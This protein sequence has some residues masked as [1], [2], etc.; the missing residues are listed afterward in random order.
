V[1]TV[2]LD[3]GAS[4][5]SGGDRYLEIYV[6][7]HDAPAYTGLTPRQQINSTPYAIRTL[8]AAAADT[9]TNAAQLGGVA[10]SGYVQTNDARLSDPRAPLA[11]SSNYI[12]NSSTQQSGTFNVNGSGTIGGALNVT[13]V[14]Q[15]LSGFKFPDASVQSTAATGSA[16]NRVVRGVISFSGNNYD[17]SENFSPAIDP[18]KSVVFLS[19]AVRQPGSGSGLTTPAPAYLVSLDSNT[20]RVAMHV[21]SSSPGLSPHKVSYQ[22]IEYK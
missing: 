3:F 16:V 11:G 14:V 5:F 21:T 9:A 22:I 15:S 13:G 2:L 10:A 4:A 18:T 1:F 8:S 17:V 7:Q 19:D 6:K 12:Q 20:I